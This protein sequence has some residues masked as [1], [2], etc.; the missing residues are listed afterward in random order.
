MLT[1]TVQG[2][3][4]RPAWDGTGLGVGSGTG[5]GVNLGGGAAV[6][7]A[8]GSYSTAEPVIPHSPVSAE[9]P[10]PPATRTLPSSSS[11]A[12]A[13]SCARSNVQNGL[14]DR[15]PGSYSSGPDRGADHQHGAIEQQ[16]CR[17][18]GRVGRDH[19]PGDRPR[20]AGRV[21]QLGGPRGRA[22]VDRPVTSTVPS[23]S[24][25]AVSGRHAVRSCR[26]WRSRSLCPGRTAP[27][28]RSIWG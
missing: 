26:R 6:D 8:S 9:H 2:R 5:I 23:R 25:V 3:P 15:V 12:G 10:S 17:S 14:H 18:E 28:R 13:A 11:V 21:V 4:P 20:P 16:R 22:L 7:V 27:P 24:S 19:V 1:V